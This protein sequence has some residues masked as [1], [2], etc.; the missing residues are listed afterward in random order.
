[1]TGRSDV[2]RAR[3]AARATPTTNVEFFAQ[4]ATARRAPRDVV[5]RQRPRRRAVAAHRC[6][7]RRR[8][9]DAST[10]FGDVLGQ[11][12]GPDYPTWSL[13][14]TVSY[15]VG[16]SFEDGQPRAGRSGAP[17]GGAR[18]ASLQLDAAESIRQAARQVRSTAE[19]ED[20]ARAGATLA[21][22]GSTP[23]S[24]ATSVG[25]STT[26]SRHAG[27]A[28]PA[29]GAGQPAAGDARLPVVA[30]ELRGAAAGA[31]A[32]AGRAVVVDGSEVQPVP[33]ETPRG[34]FR[35]GSGVQP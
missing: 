31:G 35:V 8:H 30:R 13:G 32:L 4:P 26:L 17:P 20:A 27:A 25:L 18:V 9:R 14:V 7:S 1:M 28:R 3:N 23:S 33:T 24:G 12:F 21:S 29:A 34:V 5:S 6:V 19:R 2:A 16:R 15:P 11:A 22:S 10:G